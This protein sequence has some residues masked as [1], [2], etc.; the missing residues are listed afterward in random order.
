ME[1]S[2]NAHMNIRFWWT[3]TLCFPSKLYCKC[4]TSLK[5]FLLLQSWTPDTGSVS[6]LLSQTPSSVSLSLV[7][8]QL[9]AM[10]FHVSVSLR[11]TALTRKCLM[12]NLSSV[13][14]ARSKAGDCHG[15]SQTHISRGCA[16]A[17]VQLSGGDAVPPNNCH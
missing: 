8:R 13:S 10:Y 12:I 5:N 7:W 14:A 17:L 6:L 11:Q 16:S 2:L 3:K 9:A 4:H 1:L 15:D